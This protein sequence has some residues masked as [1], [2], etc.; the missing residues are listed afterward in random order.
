MTRHLHGLKYHLAHGVCCFAPRDPAVEALRRA[1]GSVWKG[2]GCVQW[3]GTSIGESRRD[4]GEKKGC[5]RRYK[6]LTDC[7]SG[8]GEDADSIDSGAAGAGPSMSEAGGNRDCFRHKQRQ[9]AAPVLSVLSPWAHEPEPGPGGAHAHGP[10]PAR[11]RALPC[12]VA[13]LAVPPRTVIRGR[14]VRGRVCYWPTRGE[15]ITVM[16]VVVREEERVYS[17]YIRSGSERTS[18]NTST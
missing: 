3:T 5:K 7:V 9:H 17:N 1:S 8:T 14:V 6:I 18:E 4:G 13:A 15:R 11:A 12:A 10:T 16:V 2:R